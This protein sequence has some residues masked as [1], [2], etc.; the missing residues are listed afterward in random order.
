MRVCH[1]S[2]SIAIFKPRLTKLLSGCEST[3][4][5]HGSVLGFGAIVDTFRA[6]TLGQWPIMR[7][8]LH[9]K[10]QHAIKIATVKH[11]LKE[12]LCSRSPSTLVCSWVQTLL[13][14]WYF[15]I[16]MNSNIVWVP[17]EKLGWL[18]MC[19]R[20]YTYKFAGKLLRMV[21][22]MRSETKGNKFPVEAHLN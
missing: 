21:P 13:F 18:P 11:D 19:D 16:Y 4:A 5:W 3:Q 6:W 15:R 2:G 8:T 20:Q 1:Q 9:H 14:W 17:Y 10:Q 12:T 7:G 22:T